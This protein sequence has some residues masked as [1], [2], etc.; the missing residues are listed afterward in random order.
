MLRAVF[1]QLQSFRELRSVTSVQRDHLNYSDYLL[2]K[3]RWAALNATSVL[4]YE[5]SFYAVPPNILYPIIIL[6]VPLSVRVL[7]IM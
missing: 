1:C 6:L 7:S 4:Y 2:T 3:V 5:I